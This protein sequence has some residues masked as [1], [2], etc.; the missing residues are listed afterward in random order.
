M[1]R[2]THRVSAVFLSI[3]IFIHLLNHTYAVIGTAEHI[4]FMEAYRSIYRMLIIEA[5]LMMAVLTQVVTGVMLIK[6]GSGKRFGFFEKLQAY[7]GGYLAFF[8]I[9]HTSAVLFGRL[10]PELDT[11]FYFGAA[12][13]HFEP[14]H[15]F[16]LPYYFLAIV[17]FTNHLAC[18]VFFNAGGSKSGKVAGFSMIAGGFLL[19]FIIIT[20]FAGG[21]YEIEIP[22]EYKEMYQ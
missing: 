17:A 6:K 21:F 10:V 3:F 9:V 19:A 8:L 2:T 14:Y 5:V 7:S 18:A 12:G 15:F 11:N 20:A 13:M 16:F 1:L 4:A 22:A